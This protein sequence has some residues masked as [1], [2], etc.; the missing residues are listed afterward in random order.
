MSQQ[1]LIT[2]AAGIAVALLLAG[3]ASPPP[4]DEFAASWPEELP[5]EQIVG[6]SI[7]QAGHDVAL[8]ENAIAR[9]VGDTVTILLSE[10]TAAQKSST[11]TTAKDSSVEIPAA[12]FGGT[13]LSIGGHEISATV[14]TNR[15]FEGSGDSALSNKLQGN[16]PVTVAQAGDGN[17]CA[18]QK[19]R[20]QPGTRIRAHPGRDPPRDILPTTQFLVPVANA[21]CNGEGCVDEPPPGCCRA[22]NPSEYAG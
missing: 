2:L 3:C 13:P 10:S 22:L 4:Y 21:P 9:R 7:F 17:L 12:V 18:R 19:D 6:G 8:F 15:R 5:R 14:E 16:V 20:D 11:T 1:R